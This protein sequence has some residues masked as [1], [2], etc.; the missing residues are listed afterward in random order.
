MRRGKMAWQGLLVVALSLAGWGLYATVFPTRQPASPDLGNA[1]PGVRQDLATAPERLPDRSSSAFHSIAGPASA[2]SAPAHG[3]ARCGEDQQAIYAQALPDP[4]DGAI[5]LELP[6]PDPDGIVRRLPGET[7]PAGV[8][9]SGA[10]RRLDAALRNSGDAFDR[11]MAD[12]LDLGQVTPPANRNEALVLDAL[13]VD[14]PRVYGLAYTHCIGT[15]PPLAGSCARLSAMRWA[16]LDPGNATPWLWA[17]AD[18]DRRG[19]AKDQQEALQ[20][21]AAASRMDIRSDAGASA[22]AQIQMADDDLAAQISASIQAIGAMGGPSGSPLTSRCGNGASGDQQLAATCSQIAELFY[23]HSDSV[24][25]RAIGG[26]LHKLVSGDSSWLDRAHREQSRIVQEPAGQDV[27]P[28]GAQRRLLQQF[29]GRAQ[30][31]N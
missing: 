11:A 26:S 13:A 14:D 15:P 27:T 3:A 6:V 4:E 24:L 10:M 29:G 12:A 30:S 8:G 22:V 2:S 16:Q 28:C 25:W 1:T 19:D 20:H 31:A 9:Y 5:H 18:A 21:L 7:R 23:Q 17:L